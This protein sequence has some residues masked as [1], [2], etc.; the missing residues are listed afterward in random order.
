[1]RICASTHSRTRGADWLCWLPAA[2]PCLPLASACLQHVL[3]KQLA[4]VLSTSQLTEPAQVLLGESA[5]AS[6]GYRVVGL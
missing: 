1:M 5:C 2:L 4:R 3:L 6:V